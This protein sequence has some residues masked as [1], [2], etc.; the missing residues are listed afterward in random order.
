MTGVAQLKK[1]YANSWPAGALR[2]DMGDAGEA[3]WAGDRHA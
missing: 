1:M 3:I 2:S